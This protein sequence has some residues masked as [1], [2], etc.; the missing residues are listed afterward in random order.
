ME[1]EITSVNLASH[2]PSRPP[3]GLRQKLERMLAG[4][5]G[6]PDGA[7]IPVVGGSVPRAEMV[8]R[9]EAGVA[10][11]QAIDAQLL[12]LKAA[13]VQLLNA[14]NDLLELHTV[15]KG[16]LAVSLGRKA[17]ALATFGLKPQAERRALTSEERV[18]RA[19]KAR[20]TRKLRHTGGRRQK[21][22]LK[23]QG[24]VDV[25]STLAPVPPK[26]SSPGP[27]G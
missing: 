16:S 13:R 2:A 7:S 26:D 17:P 6:M 12:A 9:L 11:F 25:T 3:K 1:A 27:S 23:F 10:Y 20:Q 8:A 19:E 14:A 21:A 18:V 24:K 22:A 5:R 4:A 15:W